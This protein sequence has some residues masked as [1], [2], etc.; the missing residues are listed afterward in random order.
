MTSM[1]QEEKQEFLSGL[2]VGV[3]A[4]NDANS[5]PLAVPIWYNYKPGREIWFI[6][7]LNSHKGKLLT[8]GSRVSLVAQA[9]NPPYRYVSV[10]G[11]IRSIS[12]ASYG[13]LLSMAVRYLGSKAGKQYAKDNKGPGGVLVHVKP[14]RW[15]AVDYSR[16]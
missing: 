1:T 11:P 12:P 8:I 15:L 3:L 9:E 14:E 2:H 5:G 4:L 7:G 10:E 6:T 13:A 16:S